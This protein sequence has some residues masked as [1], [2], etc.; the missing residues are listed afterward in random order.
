MKIKR[1]SQAYSVPGPLHLPL[2]SSEILSLSFVEATWLTERLIASLYQ[3]GL[4][5]A[6]N[7]NLHLHLETF[8]AFGLLRGEGGL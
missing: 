1:I 4:N 2:G 3:V 6:T 5:T 7:V 8:R